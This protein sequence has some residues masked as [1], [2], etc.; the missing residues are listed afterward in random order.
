M[1]RK[2]ACGFIAGV[3]LATPLFPSLAQNKPISSVSGPAPAMADPQQQ[4]AWVE[5]ETC[6]VWTPSWMRADDFT[7]DYAGECKDELAEGRGRLRILGKNAIVITEW[8][9]VFH[10]GAFMGGNPAMDHIALPRD[11][12]LLLLGNSQ[13]DPDAKHWMRITYEQDGTLDICS[14]YGIDVVTV[15]PESLS[16]LEEERIQALMLEAAEMHRA[17]CKGRATVYVELLA[18]DYQP[19]AYRDGHTRFVPVIASAQF[20]LSYNKNEFSM[21]SYVNEEARQ[22]A[23]Q[24]R[25]Q[26]RQAKQEELTA[27][28]KARFATFS[29]QHG[30]RAWLK[31][32]QLEANPFRWQ[33]KVIAFPGHFER[34]VS[35]STALISSPR[36]FDTRS[37]GL[38]LLTNVSPDLF[39]EP[40]PIVVAGK[41]AGRQAIQHQGASVEFTTVELL[42]AEKCEN[43]YCSEFFYFMGLDADKY[44]WGMEKEQFP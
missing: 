10:K 26:E 2:I 43:K 42:A 12:L 32:D 41:A 34:M 35:V 17:Y 19:V 8:A 11:D 38:I 33:D 40:G 13:T 31:L 23:S 1:W 14:P 29:Q 25:Q 15:A 16:P 22:A 3:A 6:K 28:A 7:A 5:T 18:R 30:V 36:G 21:L 44:E 39:S 20:Q 37:H 27:A 9:G 4:A 24:K